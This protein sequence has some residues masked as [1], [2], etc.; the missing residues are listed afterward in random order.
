MRCC[1][2]PTRQQQDAA[3]AVGESSRRRIHPRIQ[4]LKGPRSGARDGSIV[5]L[6]GLRAAP[7]PVY[8]QRPSPALRRNRLLF[9]PFQEAIVK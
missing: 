3:H 5:M 4:H 8:R 6:L 7:T 1:A 9:F 2:A